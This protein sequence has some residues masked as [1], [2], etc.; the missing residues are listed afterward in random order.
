MID[1]LKEM[2]WFV[3]NGW[4]EGGGEGKWTYTEGRDDSV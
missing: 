3:F 4:M 2:E 1:W